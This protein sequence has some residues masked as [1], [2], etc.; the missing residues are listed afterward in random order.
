MTLIDWLIIA[1]ILVLVPIGY[2]RGLLVA[3]MGLGGFA[4][5]AAAGARLAPL[6]LEEGSGSPYAPGVAL[7]GGVIL[8]GGV[9]IVVE[10]IALS[11]RDRLPERG[12]LARADAIGGA[13]IFAVLALAIVW[14]AG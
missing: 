10:G 1:L 4:L 12:T 2:G 14:V 8:G 11:F 9:A 7:L 13:A 6:L 3:G 5:G